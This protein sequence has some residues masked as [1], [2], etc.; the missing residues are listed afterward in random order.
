MCPFPRRSGR[1]LS[2][3]LSWTR[4]HPSGSWREAG[5]KSVQRVAHL[6]AGG[7]STR[8]APNQHCAYTV[9]TRM[10]VDLGESALC[11]KMDTVLLQPCVCV[12]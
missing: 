1:P 12:L 4:L 6:K 2:H 10:K 11:V 5:K 9:V 8:L 3:S 7:K